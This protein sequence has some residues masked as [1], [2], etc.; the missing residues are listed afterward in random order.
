[1]R[2]IYAASKLAD[3]VHTLAVAPGHVRDRLLLA[4]EVLAP[5]EPAHF[6][7]HLRTQF[8]ELYSCL[9]KHGPVFAYDGRVQEG[10]IPHTLRRIRSS[11]GTKLAQL[12]Y[13]LAVAIS[14][15]R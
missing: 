12:V 15:A 3:A 13:D 2:Y 1:M 14:S 10:A 9:T 8:A 7:P 6:P 4:S 11:T 5:L